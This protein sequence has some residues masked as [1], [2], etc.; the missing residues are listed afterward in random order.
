MRAGRL[1]VIAVGLLLAGPAH[2]Q[3]TRV[4][5]TPAVDVFTVRTQGDTIVASADTSVFVSTDA[6]ITWHGSPNP[7]HA[8]V[9]IDAVWIRNQRTFAGTFGQGVFVSDDLGITWQPF[10][11]GLTGGFANSQLFV[12]DFDAR[13]DD[14]FAATEGAGVYVRNL[15]TADTWHPFGAVFE[16]NQA[17]NVN[18]IAL[19]G[20][21]LF[22]CA[23]ANGTA[24]Y[25]DPGDGDWTVTFFSNNDVIAGLVARTA[26]WTGSRWVVGTTS[27][28]FVSLDGAEPWTPAS[29]PLVGLATGPVFARG[30][31]R[32]LAVFNTTGGVFLEESHDEG[33]TWTVIE[34]LP[35]G[36]V[37]QLAARGTDLY[38]A[39]QDGLWVRSLDTASVDPGGEGGGLRFSLAGSQPARDV[40]RFRFELPRAGTASLDVFDVTGRR[41]AD[42]IGGSWTAGAQ[43]VT[44]DVRG[45]A[46]GVYAARLT[47]GGVS[48]VVRL[49]LVH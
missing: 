2:A 22:A 20:E 35:S 45:L 7:A 5:A 31:P 9:P 40:A 19:G 4:T 37:Y 11:Q 36:F 48:G 12:S 33:A 6:G 42:R 3:W 32:L 46:P 49:V 8:D 25:R 10:N 18:D 26:F 38:A 21:R 29:I 34:R 27:G 14:L 1:F 44:L 43:E 24:F 23:G 16:P 39:A 28:V 13:G 17:S 15:A 41:A 47:S 30:G